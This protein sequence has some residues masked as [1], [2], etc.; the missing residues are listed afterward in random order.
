MLIFS[1]LDSIYLSCSQI[2]PTA[3]IRA[4]DPVELELTLLFLSVK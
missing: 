3:S 4:S 1:P 2:G